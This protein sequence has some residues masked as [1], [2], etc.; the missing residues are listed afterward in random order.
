MFILN[1]LLELIKASSFHSQLN[2]C[3][4]EHCDNDSICVFLH[5]LCETNAKLSLA[6]LGTFPSVVDRSTQSLNHLLELA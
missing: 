3:E 6:G 1:I 5:Y 4:N 2:T